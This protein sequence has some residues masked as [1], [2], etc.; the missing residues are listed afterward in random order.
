MH[1]CGGAYGAMIAQTHP[2]NLLG[3]GTFNWTVPNT[4]STNVL[5]RVKAN[6]GIQPSDIS[7]APFTVNSLTHD[8]YMHPTTYNANSSRSPDAAMASLAAILASYDF[9]TGG[10]IHAAASTYSPIRTTAID[11]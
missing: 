7:D 4:P 3:S 8:L 9:G 5:I 6:S 11:V 1:T 10:T 2:M